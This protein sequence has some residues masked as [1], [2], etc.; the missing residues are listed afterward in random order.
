M[1]ALLEGTN[2]TEAASEVSTLSASVLSVCLYES[3]LTGEQEAQGFSGSTFLLPF[4]RKPVNTAFTKTGE[5]Q[6]VPAVS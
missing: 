1:Q 2:T 6:T 5:R 3:P 4:Y